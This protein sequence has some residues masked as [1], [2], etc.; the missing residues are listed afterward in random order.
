MPAATAR[1]VATLPSAPLVELVE[2]RG[3]VTGQPESLQRSYYRARETG[4]LTV[5]AA[6]L[7][8]VR[9][10]GLHPLLIWPVEWLDVGVCDDG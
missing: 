3:G 1:R 9:L 10:C 6:D 7:L 8:A 4:E 5:W 2:A